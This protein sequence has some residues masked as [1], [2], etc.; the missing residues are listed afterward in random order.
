MKNTDKALIFTSL[1]HLLLKKKENIRLKVIDVGGGGDPKR[2]ASIKNGFQKLPPEFNKKSAT[3][4]QPGT[5]IS[6]KLKTFSH[7]LLY[8]WNIGQVKNRLKG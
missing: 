2:G 8:L 5:N 3:K 7:S 4:L 6:L 1:T